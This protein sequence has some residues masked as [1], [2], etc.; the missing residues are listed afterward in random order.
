[1]GIESWGFFTGS[2]VTGGVELNLSC[3]GKAWLGRSL[4]CL[5]RF[6]RN[7]GPSTPRLELKNEAFDDSRVERSA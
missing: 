5:A 2:C 1:V 6:D 7:D 3:C 4:T